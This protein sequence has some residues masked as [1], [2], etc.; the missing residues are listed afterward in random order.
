MKGSVL[1]I[2]LMTYLSHEGDY[3]YL[4]FHRKVAFHFGYGFKEYLGL[5]VNKCPF[6]LGITAMTG[7][8]FNYAY[9]MA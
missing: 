5:D 3:V 7:Y 1:Q 4:Y 2:Q 9:I 8:A 6:S